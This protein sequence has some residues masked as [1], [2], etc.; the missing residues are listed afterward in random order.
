MLRLRLAPRKVI[1]SQLETGG[2]EEFQQKVA[3]ITKVK[4][5]FV[6]SAIFCS[7]LLL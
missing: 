3:K 4:L 5:F 7:I 2:K 6:I 1:S